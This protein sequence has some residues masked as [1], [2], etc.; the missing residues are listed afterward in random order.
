MLKLAAQQ[1][2]GPYQLIREVGQGGTAIVFQA[3][4]TRTQET[5][6]VKLLK[7]PLLPPDR[8][9]DLLT[10]LGREAETL[11]SL[12]HPSIVGL[13]DGLQCEDGPGGGFHYIVLEY[14][15]G[16][17]L[18]AHLSAGRVN[19]D[20]CLYYLE[21]I[22]DAL[23]ALHG[24]GLVYRD[25]KPSNLMMTRDGDIKLID[26][27][28]ARSS[29]DQEPAGPL[30]GSPAYVA[31]ELIENRPVG[32]ASDIWS[33][34]VLLYEMLTGQ[35]PF[36]G[37]TI[38]D[39]LHRIT[40]EPPAPLPPASAKIERVLRRALEKDPQRRY[41]SARAMVT[42]YAAAIGAST[43]W[44]FEEIRENRR[45]TE[46]KPVATS[47]AGF[48]TRLRKTL[49]WAAA[50]CAVG[51][52]MTGL[53][54]L[55]LLTHAHVSAAVQEAA[56]PAPS[57]PLPVLP[58]VP[59]M[60]PPVRVRVKAVEQERT[61]P[62]VV[63]A[64]HAPNSG[65]ARAKAAAPGK[66]TVR[67]IS[68]PAIVVAK[69]AKVTNPPPAAKP[70]RM[71]KAITTTP[72][73]PALPTAPARVTVT[74][75]RRVRFR[76]TYSV[77]ALGALGDDVHG[78]NDQGQSVG[79]LGG[80]AVL[81]DGGA[82]HRLDAP[83]VRTELTPY[84]E[85]AAINNQGQVVGFSHL[86]AFLWQ[87]GVMHDLGTLVGNQSNAT[88]LNDHGQVVGTSHNHA[89]LWQDGHVTDLGTLGG[90]ES[91][92][93]AINDQGQVAGVSYTKRGYYHAF[94][95]QD[96]VMQDLG[97]LGGPSSMAVALNDQGQVAGLSVTATG[98]THAFLWQDGHMQ[99]LGTLSGD[100]QAFGIG[101]GGEV[102][103]ASGGR[104]VLWRDG[105][106]LDLSRLAA[107]DF[108]GTLHRAMAVN[109]QGQILCYGHRQGGPAT[110]AFLLSPTREG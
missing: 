106:I 68:R 35:L 89:V 53:S 40:H 56:V 7:P 76:P 3:L 49:V 39:V 58:P 83:P 44:L 4:D 31:P 42:D 102:A 72:A 24:Q 98:A 107:P 52:L 110:Q 23:D 86:H 93:R 104:A 50:A 25:L 78:L 8:Q 1:T 64:P 69:T 18:R 36:A 66:L 17:T 62:A 95:W 96:G 45:E 9:A 70:V 80:F 57:L 47:V 28:L 60:A 16:T 84:S 99:D 33:L 14:I 10:R 67:S 27:D 90:D 97:T 32:P 55:P 87:A 5:V 12:S 41:P 59:V 15:D 54:V 91:H 100:S 61:T 92:A 94:L 43:R 71:A 79:G 74:P 20:H 6:A 65:A 2:L 11:A 19:P 13:R 48:Q 34:G 29:Q 38:A 85:A 73:P 105:K 108:G 88:A 63:K 103:G 109:A 101:P 81:W 22:A 51:L 77:T 46:M 82:V 37:P 21:Q 26:F 75:Q 30:V